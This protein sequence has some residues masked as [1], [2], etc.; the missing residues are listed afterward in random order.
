I[1][2]KDAPDP[3]PKPKYVLTIRDFV[4]LAEFIACELIT[5]TAIEANNGAGILLFFR[6]ALERAIRIRKMFLMH[7]S[8]TNKYLSMQANIAHIYF[9][10]VLKKVRYVLFKVKGGSGIAFNMASKKDATNTIHDNL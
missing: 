8:E 9:I 1:D 7:L 4:P 6:T 2:K 5:T 10:S 3:P